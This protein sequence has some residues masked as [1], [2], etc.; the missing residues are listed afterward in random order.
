LS[1]SFLLDVNV[2]VARFWPHHDLHARA[3]EW[4]DGHAAGG[5]ATCPITQMGFVRTLSQPAF[6]DPRVSPGDALKLFK[7]NLGIEGHEFWA[8]DLTYTEALDYFAPRLTG[9]KQTTDAYL[10]RLAMHRKGELVTFDRGVL[11]LAGENEAAR[12]AL[13]IL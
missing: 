5:W 11:A 3:K 8:D 1:A 13:V 4:L 12:E 10:L 2:L 6:A 7:S 9:H